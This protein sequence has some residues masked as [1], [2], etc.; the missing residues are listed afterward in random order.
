VKKNQLVPVEST[1]V[2][3]ATQTVRAASIPRSVVLPR[4]RHK[5]MVVKHFLTGPLAGHTVQERTSIEFVCGKRYQ[6]SGSGSYEILGIILLGRSEVALADVQ[7]QQQS[8]P[9]NRQ[10]ALPAHSTSSSRDLVP[11]RSGK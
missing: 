7:T 10:R 2:S 1:A 5:Y 9:E 11:R 4:S 3:P 6:G 8:L